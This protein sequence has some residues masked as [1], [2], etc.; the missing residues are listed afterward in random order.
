MMACVLG[1][2]GKGQ[3][4]GVKTRVIG[5]DGWPGNARLFYAYGADVVEDQGQIASRHLRRAGFA[6]HVDSL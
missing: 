3:L 2:K 6:S 5:G 1:S 4:K